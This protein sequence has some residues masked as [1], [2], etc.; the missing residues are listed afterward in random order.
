[1]L[2]RVFTL[3]VAL[4]SATAY[5]QQDAKLVSSESQTT[6]NSETIERSKPEVVIDP[7]G[8]G[9]DSIKAIYGAVEAIT[10]LAEDQDLQEVSRLRRRAYD[11]TLSALETEGYF[12][13][14][15]TLEVG[16]DYQGGETWDISIEPGGRTRVRKVKIDFSGQITQ[17]EFDERIEHIRTSWPLKEGDL[18]LNAK[19]SEAKSDLLDEVKTKDF[20]FARYTR[21]R[22]TVYAEEDEA[23]LALSVRSGPR[24]RMGNLYTSGLKRV[25]RSLIDRYVVYKPGDPYD[26]E[27]LDEWQQALQ[28][29]TFFRGAFVTLDE[30]S[31]DQRVDS[32]GE[33]EIP[34]LVRVTEAPAKVFTGSLGIESDYGL[35]AEGLYRHNVIFGLP[36]W[37]ET[38]VGVDKKRQRFFHDI[39]F[40]PTVGGFRNSLG[41][42]YERENIEGVRQER[43]AAGVKTRYDFDG[44]GRV[45]YETQGSLM[46]V[47]NKTQIKGISQR[48]EGT[49]LELLGQF[50]RRDV[51][52]KYDPREGNL[53]DLDLGVH[54]PFKNRHKTL[55]RAGLRVQQWFPIG[56]YDVF[57]IRGEVGRVWPRSDYIPLG[58]GFRTGGARS[59]RG[60]KYQ[61]I[62]LHRGRATVGAPAMAVASV[63]YIHYFNEMF[64]M[65][66][67]VDAG[68]AA[69]SFKDFKT[70]LGY[71]VGAAVRTPAGPFYVDLA[72]GQ[73]D[74]SVRLHFSLGIAF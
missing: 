3:V 41:T 12:D 31:A 65:S 62:G 55:Y 27:K 50:L 46:A 35:R 18:F 63:E 45:E 4:V 58:F 57:T 14:V 9:P 1:M 56:K 23:D 53:I 2:L 10:R 17:P 39:H 60:Y 33:M 61:S 40:P 34:V 20:Y 67:F 37:S 28:S 47:W 16:T 38:G 43:A 7:G 66:V 11:A 42:I 5:A 49:A 19:W 25:P 54:Y 74:K 36:L 21:T 15:V 51:N 68:D 22:A 71:G 24:V 72:Y 13:P 52:D 64:G 70:H 73:R 44:K 30:E 29:T 26:Q 48:Q 32:D 59:I 8:V 69:E 6:E